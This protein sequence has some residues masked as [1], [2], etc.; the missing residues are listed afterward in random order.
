MTNER[1]AAT[2]AAGQLALVVFLL[3]PQAPTLGLGL[4]VAL[5][6]VSSVAVALVANTVAHHFSQDDP[7]RELGLDPA[8]DTAMDDLTA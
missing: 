1:I 6:I 3:V 2:A 4:T 7:W 5:A 8:W